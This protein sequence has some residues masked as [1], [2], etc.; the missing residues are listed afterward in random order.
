[1]RSNRRPVGSVNVKE[2]Q[3]MSLSANSYRL[4]FALCLL[5]A[6]AASP[7]ISHWGQTT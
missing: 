1:M 3:A 7:H 2:A 4:S 6:T 5:S